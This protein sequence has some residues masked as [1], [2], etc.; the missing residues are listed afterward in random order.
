MYF[1]PENDPLT[2]YIRRCIR[3]LGKSE[4]L[5]SEN[6]SDETKL[7]DTT[8]IVQ[9]NVPEELT[10]LFNRINENIFD[11]VFIIY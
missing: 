11:G 6:N 3:A 1:Y 5:K 2:N 9:K 7:N 10:N 4:Q 8:L